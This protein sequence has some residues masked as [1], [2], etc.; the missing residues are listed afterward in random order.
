MA[1][2]LTLKAGDMVRIGDNILIKCEALEFRQNRLHFIIE[3][4]KEV[5]IE[6][7]ENGLDIKEEWRKLCKN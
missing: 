1:L 6:R 7:L 4:P 5:G 3:A 2:A